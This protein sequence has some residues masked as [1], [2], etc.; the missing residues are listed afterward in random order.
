MARCSACL[1]GRVPNAPFVARA[2]GRKYG[3]AWCVPSGCDRRTACNA[4]RAAWQDAVDEF[5]AQ[6]ETVQ[7]ER[8]IDDASDDQS[9]EEEV[10]GRSDTDQTLTTHPLS[11]QA[12]GSCLL[13]D[14]PAEHPAAACP[15]ALNGVD[16][17]EDDDDD[18]ED[19]EEDG[20]D[21][22]GTAGWGR[23]KRTF[24]RCRA[25][26]APSLLAVA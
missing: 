19:E 10:F 26:G 9:E 8:S 23:N 12:C 1:A 20:E 11:A 16:S 25:R 24:Y 18:L 6:S 15:P 21:E 4:F 13:V 14:W 22:T 3:R 7:L 5:H 2:Q 17:S